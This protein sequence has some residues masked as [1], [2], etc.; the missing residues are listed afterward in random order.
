MDI[1][2]SQIGFRCEQ[3]IKTLLE[4]IGEKERR[5]MSQIVVLFIEQ[6]VKEYIK[7][8]PELLPFLPEYLND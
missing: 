2:T 3:D 8:H 4:K 6:G 5:S 7:S 1:K